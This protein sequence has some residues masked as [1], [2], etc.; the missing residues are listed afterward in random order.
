MKR[1]HEAKRRSERPKNRTEAIQFQRTLIYGLVTVIGL[2]G[3]HIISNEKNE[4]DP[5]EDIRAL[6]ERLSE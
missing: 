1:N 5:I 4:S 2:A 6:I 3:A